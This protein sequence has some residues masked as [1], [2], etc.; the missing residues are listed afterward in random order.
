METWCHKPCG[1]SLKVLLC[2]SVLS[3]GKRVLT[4]RGP[5]KNGQKD[6]LSLL[7]GVRVMSIGWVIMGHTISRYTNLAAIDNIN[8]ISDQLADFNYVPVNG[9]FYAVDTFFWLSGLLMAYFFIVEIEKEKSLS[10]GK[11][12]LVYVHRYLR[13]NPT[14]LFL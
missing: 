5:D 6:P 9:A 12:L 2:F 14:Y 11:I 13:I 10:A 8:S 7:D 3:N 1:K 4:V